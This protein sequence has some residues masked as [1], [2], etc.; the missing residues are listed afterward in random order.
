M[1]WERR[2]KEL[3]LRVDELERENQDLRRKL[4]YPENI[5]PP[6]QEMQQNDP[7][8]KSAAASADVH[9]KST[10][11][12]K[13][14]L[15]RNLF[16]GREDVFARRWYSVQKEKGGY[17][18]V[19]ANE[20]R[21]G[22]C[23][24]PKGKCSKCE[25]RVLVPL[26][27]AII[28]KHLSGKDANGQDVIGMYPILP[29]DTCYFL[30]ID[31]DDGAWRENVSAVRN[32]CDEWKIPCGVERSRSGEGAHL[33]VFFANA[34]SCTTARKLGSALLTAAMEREGKLKLDA[35]DRM[36][37]CQDTLPNGGF[38]N[39][40]ALPLQ[41]QARKKGNSLFVDEVFQPYP[42]QW[43]Y[44]SSIRKL[45]AE[46]VDALIKAHSHGDALG[47]LCVVESTTKPWEKQ[48][49][50]VLSAL[51]FYGV[52]HIVRAN[53]IYIPENGFA[54]R[55]R[56]QLLR[57]AAFRN[58][59]FY[60]SQ[61]MRLPIYDKP[62]IICAAEERDGYLA[63]PRCC[64]SD[65]V[66]LLENTAIS[67]EIEDKTFS[68]NEIRVEFK[69]ELRQE[70]IPAAEALLAHN[71]GVLSATTAFGK[72]VIAAYLIGQRKVNTLVLVHTQALLNQWKKALSEFLDINESLPELPKKRGRKKERS[73][74]GQLGGAKNNLSGFV[75]IAIMQSL[76]SGNEVR[77]LVKNYGMVIVDECHHVSAVSFE[78][79]LKEVNAKYV[80]GLTATPTRQDGHQPIIHMQ[81]GPIRYQVDAKVQAE[82]RPFDH[83]VI[84]KFTSF[85]QPVTDEVPWKITDA[86]A[87]MQVNEDRNNKIVEDVLAVVTEGRTPVVLTERYDHAKLIA[88]IL[89]EKSKN[90]VL[91]SGKGTSKEK[92]EILLGLSQIPADEPLI[93]VATGR[94][95]G[96]GFD[97][98][99]L[100]T[101][102]L[103]M[104]VSWKGTL[105]QYAGRLHRNYEGKQEVLIYDYVDVRVPMLERM[106]H[107]R[108]S[109][110][111]AIGYTVKGDRTAPAAENRIFGQEEY[112]DTFLA[113]ISNAQKEILITSPYLHVA[114]VKRFLKPIPDGIHVTIVTGNESCFK[115]DAWEKASKA[116]KLLED[117]G[118]TVILQSKV[119]QRY[120]VIDNN[121]LWYGGINF[122]GFE[123]DNH[124]AMRICSA[125]LANEL[126][127]YIHSQNTYEQL[128]MY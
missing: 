117:N 90:V 26:E 57:L 77:D 91:L 3:Q 75:D 62:R 106:Y 111:A 78:Q 69:G 76:I 79:V 19:C 107:K 109:G 100:D 14:R 81:C 56:N 128:E 73:L 125:E 46:D 48:K 16:R 52:Q 118:A 17:A 96:E 108:L 50:V 34:V 112:W 32:M 18:P 70:Q 12:E 53:M 54:P 37:P 38:G 60:K 42:D 94:Y 10:P 44:L 95:V 97:L 87:A 11:E 4:G 1:D 71:N 29:D 121:I 64:E 89:R 22:V 21:Y 8:L 35:Y 43:A 105:A 114:Q 55:V 41:G 7:C 5:F 63:L 74:I 126:A 2:C 85:A 20:W 45:D 80:Y 86:Y 25:N 58:P 122:L 93:L 82:K 115:P 83:A 72:T 49:K 66:N 39:L 67:Y 120:A 23:I 28:Y 68:G 27:D 116:V 123:K 103:A 6:V 99:R 101:L 113:D 31:F 51:D 104:P 88:E 110:Y 59:D 61:S 102:F 9:M 65:L 47:D 36:F 33:W 92:R 15:F 124:G 30:A 127:S 84:P 40:I 24:K 98:P 13:I 119:Y